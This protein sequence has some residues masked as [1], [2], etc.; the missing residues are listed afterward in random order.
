MVE[1]GR[2]APCVSTRSMRLVYAAVGLVRVPFSQQVRPARPTCLD[3]PQPRLLLLRAR[4]ESSAGTWDQSHA[5]T[6]TKARI[7]RD[8][9]WL[10]SQC[11]RRAADRRGR[12]GGDARRRRPR[13]PRG[14]GRPGPWPGGRRGRTDRRAAG[15]RQGAP[16]RRLLGDPGPDQHPS[17]HLPE[18]HPS[19]PTS[20]QRIAVHVAD[21]AVPALGGPRRGGGLRL[22]VDRSGRARPRWLHDHDGPPLRAPAPRRRPDL[23]RDRRGAGAGDALPPDSRL[24]EPVGE[25]RRPATGQRGA[26]RRRDPRRQRAAGRDP[27]RP[28]VGCDGADRAGAVLPVL[29]LRPT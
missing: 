27:S 5:E 22:D 10:A 3:P 13:D 11:D 15:D 9:G 24:D 28:F 1:T 26:G 16:G 29:G 19:L 6:G 14:L 23:R 4:S 8:A 18:P 25:G 12:A 2:T 17:P 7:V 20:C 21:D